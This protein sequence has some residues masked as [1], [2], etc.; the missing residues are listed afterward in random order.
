MERNDTNIGSLDAAMRYLGRGMS[1][2]PVNSVNKGKCTCRKEC[3]SPGKHPVI[4]SWKVYQDRRPTDEEIRGWFTRYRFAGVGI[5]TGA[6]SGIIV[7]D[8]DGAEGIESLDGMEIPLTPAAVTG[9][10]GRHYYF[11]HP[12]MEVR[13]FTR[14]LPG[15]DLR[16][17]GGYVVA[18]PSRHAS[19]HQYYW[20]QGRA[21]WETPLAECPDW[22]LELCQGSQTCPTRQTSPT[23]SAICS[24]K[25]EIGEGSRHS[26]LV[27]YAGSLRHRGCTQAE[28]EPVLLE[29][30]TN[31]CSPPLP[32]EEVRA[33]ARSMER[34]APA[35]H[36][37]QVGGRGFTEPQDLRRAR[38]LGS[39]EA[40]PSQVSPMTDLG[41]AERLVS[42]H[43]ADLRFCHADK[44]WLIWDGKHWKQDDDGEADR[45]AKD[46]VRS[47]YQEAADAPD[48]NM[49]RALGIHAMRSQAHPRIR[50]MISL[51]ESEPQ[52]AVRRADMDA[53]PWLLNV[54]NGTVDLR[55]GDGAIPIGPIRPIG[56]IGLR[57][58]R[59]EDLLTRALRVDYDPD[60]ECPLWHGFL[61]R[62][63]GDN[64]ELI[65][66][67]RR[68]VGY[69][70]TGIVREQCLLILWGAGANGKSTF[71]ETIM[72]LL[73][74]YAVRTRAESLMVQ[75]NDSI[76]ND[77]ARLAGARMVTAMEAEEGRRLAESLV[78]SLTGGDQIAARFLNQEFFEFHPEFKIWLGTNHKPVIRGSDHAMWRRIR[79]VPFAVTIPEE[80]QDRD[81]RE[82]LLAE[83]PGILAW[84][85]RGCLEWQRDGL[86]VPAEVRS[87][88]DGY[89]EEMDVL[90]GFIAD[91][92]VIDPSSRES[93][94]ALY[95][96]YRSW[97][98]ENGEDPRSQKWFGGKLRERG[99]D[100]AKT[101]T[102][103]RCRMGVRLIVAD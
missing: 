58:H 95:E 8:A 68:A 37:G 86:G 84:A 91:R 45:R 83:L 74:T 76:P 81:L 69:S 73:G 66:F 18:P 93:A 13:N 62:V 96:A 15:L 97:C 2:I 71:L 11:R 26:S 51:A 57:E 101:S 85:V 35:Y 49:A 14:R 103:V 50:A 10:G 64:E 48:N 100:D 53:D 88:T 78:K 17:D 22:L 89:R 32:E 6:V 27:S 5:V 7:L 56:P 60:A 72:S 34:Y 31:R 82:K 92:C 52:I 24:S 4:P 63:M 29:M 12:G 1:V 99:F 46:T 39:A 21:P 61:R 25:S 38:H 102:G 55:L 40:S 47:I 70:L 44:K 30:N 43:G 94:K 65:G 28:I 41:N 33:I 67:L 3:A 16:G 42:W 98:A 75:R 90:G 77:I 59:R 36:G 23:K 9:S 20:M 54:N 80:E 19:G 79:L 87:A